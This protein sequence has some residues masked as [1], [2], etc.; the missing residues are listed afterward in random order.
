M[1]TTGGRVVIF[2]TTLRDGEQ[3]PGATLN[4]SEK[5]DIA[6]QLA[7]LG[8]DVIEAGF[9]I[10]S[11]GDFEAVRRVAEEVHG[12]TIAGLARPMADD[13]DRAWEAV[14]VNEKPRIH[15]FISSSDIH[16]QHQLRMTRAE[17]LEATRTMVARAKAHTPD[18]EFSPMDATRSDLGFV[19]DLISAAIESGANTINVPDTVGF[20]TPLEFQG[21]LRQ[22]QARV[23]KMK[24]VVLSVHCHNDLGM[25]TSNSLAA[26][27]VGARQI[28]C[29]INGIGERA[30]NAA[31][32]EVVMALNTRK[33]FYGVETGVNMSEIYRTSR[34]VSNYTGIFVQPNKAVVGANAFAHESGIHQD[35]VLKERTTYEIM[36]PK[37]V[38]LEGSNIVLGKHSGRHAFRVRLSQLGYNLEGEELNRAFRAFK[39][40]ADRKKVV[41]D[42]DLEAIVVDEVR[43]PAEIFHLDQVQVSCGDH[44]IPTASVRVI[45]PKGEVLADAA[46]G[47]GP[48]DAVYKAINRIICLPNQ[49]IELSVRSVTAGLDAVG[50]VTIRIESEGRI[51]VGRGADTDIIV[52]SAKA[53]MH[54]LNKLAAVKLGAKSLR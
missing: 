31:L 12:P 7:K 36:D 29:T 5:L 16:L 18:I 9:P 37:A 20:T 46:L 22:I 54:A 24:D 50:E 43:G 32:E 27:E 30:G 21:F 6:K 47:N 25:A 49:L 45:D 26:V 40:L 35:G 3:S 11:P 53:Y 13:I 51:F 23:P 52:A 8:V 44:N 4:I 48:V 17:V 33:D 19:C 41:S 2:D 10:S 1:D 15:V 38:G 39:E 28:E 34:M 42:P 14:R